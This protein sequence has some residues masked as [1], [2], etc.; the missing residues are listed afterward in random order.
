[1][2]KSIAQESFKINGMPLFNI[3]LAYDTPIVEDIY[4][5]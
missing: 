2:K 1:M 3:R 4:L 5:Q